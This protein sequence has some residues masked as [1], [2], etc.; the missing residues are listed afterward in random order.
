[1]STSLL[2]LFLFSFLF[3]P[4]LSFLLRHLVLFGTCFFF[5]LRNYVSSYCKS[6]CLYFLGH[7][8]LLSW[9]CKNV[10]CVKDRFLNNNCAITLLPRVLLLGDAWEPIG[11]SPTLVARP[12]IDEKQGEWFFSAN[13]EE[14][15]SYLSPLMKQS[16]WKPDCLN[17]NFSSLICK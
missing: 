9:M 3:F 8:L 12:S 13:K 10:L 11:N 5:F 15:G 4:I 17:P 16:P 1:M 2:D 7:L 14:G 6:V